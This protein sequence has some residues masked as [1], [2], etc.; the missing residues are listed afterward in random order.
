MKHI[1]FFFILFLLGSISRAQMVQ[2]KEKTSGYL[3]M[4]STIGAKVYFSP[5]LEFQKASERDVSEYPSFSINTGVL[6]ELQRGLTPRFTWALTSGYSRTSSTMNQSGYGYVLGDPSSPDYGNTKYYLRLRSGT[7][8]IEDLFIGLNMK[9]YRNKK[10]AIAPLGP[11][12]YVG[13]KLHHVSAD[14]SNLVFSTS[15]SNGWK[16]YNIEYKMED[17]ILKMNLPEINLGIGATSAIK[18]KLF[19]DY[20][21]EAGYVIYDYLPNTESINRSMKNQ[22]GSRLRFKQL[23]NYHIGLC[24]PF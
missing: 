2:V 12:F 22:I 9:F 19:L 10:A 15:Q 24:Y 21:I 16:Y 3:G 5:S 14:F 18:K 6:L 4:K 1:S 13:G 17:P 8:K 7:P 20:S 11:Y 23:L